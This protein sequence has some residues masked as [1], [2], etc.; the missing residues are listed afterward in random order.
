MASNRQDQ[1]LRFL[2]QAEGADALVPFLKSVKDLEG[3]SD[4]T[5]KAADALLNQLSEA[6][7]LQAVAGQYE[8]TQQAVE[9]L[10]QKAEAAKAKA[11]GLATE[12]ASTENP[13]KRQQEA[14]DRA[15]ASSE[16]L[17][18]QY[19]NQ[20]ATLAILSAQ[21]QVAGVNTADFA[22]AQ[23]DIAASA[24]AALTGLEGLAASAG[25]ANK[26]TGILATGMAAA[27][28]VISSGRR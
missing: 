26:Q 21:L 23:A 11:A 5:R 4:D 9:K 12:L 17:A 24:K 2:V 27:G 19:E 7:K 14:F 3:A 25:A 13:S 10:G 22:A 15:A 18:A 20:K 1:I 6:T 28:K 16:K 8:R